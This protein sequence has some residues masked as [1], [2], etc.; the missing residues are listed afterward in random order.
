MNVSAHFLKPLPLTRVL[1]SGVQPP[2]GFTAFEESERE[3]KRSPE[4]V[5]PRFLF[6][7]RFTEPFEKCLPPWVS[8]IL[9]NKVYSLGGVTP[10][11]KPARVH[12][13]LAAVCCSLGIV[14]RSIP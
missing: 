7:S 4:H 13:D 11:S 9:V 2:H 1:T 5:P 3:K 6:P 8:P 14:V 12:L 10:M